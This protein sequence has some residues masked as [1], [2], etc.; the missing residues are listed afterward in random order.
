ML[1]FAAG[2]CAQNRSPTRLGIGL[3][4]FFGDCLFSMALKIASQFRRATL[5]LQHPVCENLLCPA[6][7]IPNPDYRWDW[8]PVFPGFF[9]KLFC[10]RSPT[11]VFQAI[12]F[13]IFRTPVVITPTTALILGPWWINGGLVVI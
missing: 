6:P 13:W 7:Y 1:L 9:P 4:L 3:Q 5:S 10:G 2:L 8:G 11:N 12:A